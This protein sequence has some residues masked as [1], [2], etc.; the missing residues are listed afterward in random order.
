M[1]EDGFIL[2][3]RESDKYH[4]GNLR[5]SQDDNSSRFLSD[6][7]TFIADIEESLWTLNVFIHENPELAFQ[8]YQT[9]QA[10]TEF[11]RLQGKDW[12]VTPSAYGM[13]TA[14]VAVYDSGQE[15][16]VVS[17]NVEMGKSPKTNHR[18]LRGT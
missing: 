16:P 15:G 3:P 8:E 11:V 17:F 13:E 2:V 14:W 4:L 6:I 18:R 9:H 5:G 1:E 10:L 12:R 7:D